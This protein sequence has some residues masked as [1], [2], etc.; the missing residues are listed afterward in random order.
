M[1]TTETASN[2][3][4]PTIADTSK[5]IK[6]VEFYFSDSNLPRDRFLQEEL[7]KNEDG[8]I[9]LS[10]IGSFKRMQ[11]LSTDLA[12]IAEALK[13]SKF[14]EVSAD[15]TSVRRIS[16]L[17]E[18]TA[19]SMKTSVLVRGFNPETTT[20]EQLE[21]FFASVSGKVTAI[22]LRRNAQ[23]KTFKGSVFL[24]L[25]CEEE[26]ARLVELK[27]LTRGEETLEI[28]SMTSF[29]EDQNAKQM[30]R[31]SKKS[32]ESS[33]EVAPLSVEDVKKMVLTVTGC[34]ANM[35]HRLLRTAL[36]SKGPVAFVENVTAE[37]FSVVRFK[38]PVA[39]DLITS[40]TAE[41]GITMPGIEQPL[42][43]REPTEEEVAL[44]FTKMQEFKAKAALNGGGKTR[45]F[46]NKNKR[47][48][49]A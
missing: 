22:R 31:A 32:E 35:D 8:W 37:G 2:V 45:N 7:K 5:I 44:F 38:E 4:V 26:T 42:Q 23:S 49:R 6:Q 1:T 33:E 41:G 39:A 27:T 19:D 10:T 29:M 18:H 24:H 13:D 25:S 14:V 47:I 30:A 36:S 20:L 16:A 3:E 15:G 11:A 17:P 48:R 12:V 40:I 28:M 21:E 46:H 34:P 9:A 43:V